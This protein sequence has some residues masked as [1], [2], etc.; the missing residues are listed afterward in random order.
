MV[1]GLP[2]AISSIPS[3]REISDL[4]SGL[5]SFDPNQQNQIHKIFVKFEN[6][7][8]RARTGKVIQKQAI[9]EFR[10]PVTPK[11]FWVLLKIISKNRS[12]T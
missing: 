9:K 2:V 7:I 10:F 12:I 5:E 8:H 11:M 6:Q 1:F 4:I 3:Q